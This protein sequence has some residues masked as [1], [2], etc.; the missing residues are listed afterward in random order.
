MKISNC[1]IA[2]VVLVAGAGCRSD[3]TRVTSTSTSQRTVQTTAPQKAA[4]QSSSGASTVQHG[5]AGNLDYTIEVIPNP[6]LTATSREGDKPTE[7]YSS[8]IIAVYV[9]PHNGVTV[10]STNSSTAPTQNPAPGKK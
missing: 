1:L 8:N 10:S 9:H 2:F 6:K 4:P 3:R 5:T 7:V